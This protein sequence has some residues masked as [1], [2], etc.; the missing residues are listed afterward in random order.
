MKNKYL[1]ISK[2]QRS[3]PLYMRLIKSFEVN[4]FFIKEFFRCRKK[5]YTLNYPYRYLTYSP[6]FEKDF[7][8]KFEDIKD[9]TLVTEDR[10]FIIQQLFAYCCNLKGDVAECGVFQGGTA[11][12]LAKQI[13]CRCGQNS[14]YLYLFDTFTGMPETA[15][16]SRDG[17][18]AGDFANTSFEN[19]KNLVTEFDF[20]K[21]YPGE[22]PET[23]TTIKDKDFCFVHIDVDLYTSTLDC[24]K[25]FY[26]RM[27]A[28]GML[29]C[30][31]YGFYQYQ[32]AAKAAVDEFL[33]DK[34]EVAIPLRTG[35]CFI[36][37][38]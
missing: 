6:W 36:I 30:D 19:V 8:E 3:K 11:L 20:V 10:V 28:G 12:F 17:H 18:V 4:I 1:S 13:S 35:Q 38:L 25:F 14:K 7:L 23:F 16:K 22:I 34:P 29:L 37:K 2:Y 32:K 5:N 33:C 21:I 26:D 15:K 9:H 27:V 24:L 31:D